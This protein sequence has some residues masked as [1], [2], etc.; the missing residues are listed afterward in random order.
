MALAVTMRWQL[1]GQCASWL[2]WVMLGK[3]NRC[4]AHLDAIS[5]ETGYRVEAHVLLRE[6]GW[7]GPSWECRLDTPTGDVASRRH[8]LALTG[9]GDARLTLEPTCNAIKHAP[10]PS[11]VPW[12]R[13]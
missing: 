2:P 8:L 3:S 6:A 7:R 13:E 4:H 9:T 12:Y 11:S 10:R 5:S 1:P